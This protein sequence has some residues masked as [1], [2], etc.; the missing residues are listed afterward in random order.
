[1]TVALNGGARKQAAALRTNR[2]MASRFAVQMRL[3]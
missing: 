3:D 2:A 1:M